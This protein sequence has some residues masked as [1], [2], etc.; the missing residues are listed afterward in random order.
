M[1][2]FTRDFF[3]AASK[4]SKTTVKVKKNGEVETFSFQKT[5]SKNDHQKK[6]LFVIK[7]VLS[8]L[9]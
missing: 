9:I 2:F 4:A 6:N 7:I 3:T 8:G 5:D 1:N